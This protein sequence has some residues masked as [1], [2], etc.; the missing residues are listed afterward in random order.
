MDAVL[1]R[2]IDPAKWR[3][4]AAKSHPG[5]SVIEEPMLLCSRVSG[6]GQLPGLLL[7]CCLQTCSTAL[8]AS[9]QTLTK[10]WPKHDQVMAKS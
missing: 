3:Y 4:R 5:T 2:Q 10:S 6:P 8:K 9:C 1:V 7:L